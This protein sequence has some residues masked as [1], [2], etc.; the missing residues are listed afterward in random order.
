MELECNESQSGEWHPASLRPPS[1]R[2]AVGKRFVM[3]RSD[4]A[5]PVKITIPC[6]KKHHLPLSENSLQGIWWFRGKESLGS[7]VLWV[8]G[9]T[10]TEGLHG[11]PHHFAVFP[12]KKVLTR[13]ICWVFFKAQVWPSCSKWSVEMQWDHFLIAETFT[14]KTAWEHSSLYSG[15]WLQALEFKWCK[16]SCIIV[17]FS[18]GHHV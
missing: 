10:P 2:I 9:R 13:Y 16:T 12:G 7:K 1:I 17:P 8:W 3:S 14:Y 15:T 4:I 6:G 18:E 11:D 5:K